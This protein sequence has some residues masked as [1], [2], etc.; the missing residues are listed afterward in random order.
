MDTTATVILALLVVV[1]GPL[2]IFATKK[3]G[4]KFY[5]TMQFK[6]FLYTTFALHTI[7]FLVLLSGPAQ[8]DYQIETTPALVFETTTS[9]IFTE[10]EV[11]TRGEA[12]VTTTS[13]VMIPTTVGNTTI[14]ASTAAATTTAQDE[15]KKFPSPTPVPSASLQ[16]KF[17]EIEIPE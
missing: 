13:K 5:L 3:L 7:A 11:T 4:E 9:K 6:V 14:T 15:N 16:P 8:I 2:F 1:L 12:A 10:P 17:E